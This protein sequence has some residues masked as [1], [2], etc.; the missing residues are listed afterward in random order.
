M[1][2][3][4][5]QAIEFGLTKRK[6]L[7]SYVRMDEKYFNIELRRQSINIGELIEEKKPTFYS[8]SK[9]IYTSRIFQLYGNSSTYKYDVY[10][11]V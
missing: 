9:Q 3:K 1:I 4:L 11:F 6:D 7:A 5:K 2:K 10:G 8:I